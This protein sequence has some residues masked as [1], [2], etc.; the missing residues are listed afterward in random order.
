MT[1]CDKKTFDKAV[2]LIKKGK[3]IS[4]ATET[5]YGVGVIFDNKDA[6]DSL[7]SVKRRSPDKPFSMML[8]D[9]SELDKYAILDERAKRIVNKF[10]PGEITILVKAK[11]VPDWVTLGTGIVGIRIPNDDFVRNL[12]RNV[13]KPMLVTSANRSGMPTLTKYE[14]VVNDF[15]ELELIIEGECQSNL[16][17]TIINTVGDIKIIRVGSVSEQ[18]ILKCLED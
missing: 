10:M 18:E 17:S 13:G 1:N 6:F 14:D 2:D 11:N 7:V 12:I 5:V 9:I 3:V 4:F 15:K 16:P 8:A